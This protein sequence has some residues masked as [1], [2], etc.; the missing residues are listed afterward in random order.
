M[1]VQNENISIS[2]FARNIGLKRNDV[3]DYMIKNKYIYRQYYGKEKEKSKNIAFPKYDT[4]NGRGFFEMNERENV[5]NKG[6]NNINI[7]ITPKGQEY[8]I[9]L[10][11]KEKGV[12]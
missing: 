5:F 9:K 3:I 2:E 4:K 10:L 8:F 11:N 7:Q 12:E 1:N 6:K